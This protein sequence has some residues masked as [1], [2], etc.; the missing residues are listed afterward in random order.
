MK[1]ELYT[2]F[3]LKLTDYM[4]IVLKRGFVSLILAFFI[5]VSCVP[6]APHDNALDPY[7][8]T[9]ANTGISLKG[10]VL[11]KNDPH[12]PIDSCLIQILPEQI[13]DSSDSKGSFQF[14]NLNPGV[15][16]LILNRKG[17]ERDTFSIYPDTISK[18]PVNFYL[19]GI[20]SLNTIKIYSEYFD[21]WW[22]DPFTQVNVEITV[23]DP[24]G[25]S[26]IKSVF[27]EMPAFGL[28]K[29]FN[30]TSE[31]DSF[32]LQLKETDFPD[33]NIFNM[34]GKPVQIHLQDDS[35]LQVK[36]GPHYLI[37]IIDNAPETLEP[38]GLQTV[39]NSPLFK[40]QPYGAP[41]SFNH[42]VSVFVIAAG[43][44]ILI[45]N[46]KYIP[47]AQ[48]EYQFPDSLSSGTYFW[49]VGIRDDIGN[50]ARSKEATFIVP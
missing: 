48:T 11:Q 8:Q 45:H 31:V 44:P 25:I 50:F 26:D 13:F 34:I 12:L 33:E 18:T 6:E 22:P 4:F 10:N 36:T 29:T 37:R 28:K 38:A 49:T 27:L 21:Q 24:D 46:Q 23:S 16:Q 20:P 2:L 32:F 15:H 7:H 1:V 40:W 43:I 41:F 47:L 35:N 42:E 14:Y 3:I 5:I 39:N 17:F 19:N 9:A 30:Q